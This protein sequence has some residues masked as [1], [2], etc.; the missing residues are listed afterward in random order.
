MSK[1][2]LSEESVRP[3]RIHDLLQ[4]PQQRVL[5]PE[6]RFLCYHSSSFTHKSNQ[7][8]QEDRENS[9]RGRLPSGVASGVSL[10]LL[11]A[12]PA[13]Q[14]RPLI[15]KFCCVTWANWA[16]SRWADPTWVQHLPSFLNDVVPDWKLWEDRAQW[17]LLPNAQ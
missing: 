8:P 15:R 17:L 7:P 6:R 10:T 4:D 14:L 12:G 5:G 9:G 11:A 2:A 16:Y 1:P 13:S 3:E